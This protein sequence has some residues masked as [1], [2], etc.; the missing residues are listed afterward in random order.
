MKKQPYQPISCDFH[1]ELELLALRRIVCPIRYLGEQGSTI[2]IE[3]CISDLYTRNGEEF[4]LLPG[5]REIR[6]DRLISVNGILL[7]NY[8]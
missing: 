4:L 6:L 3:A 5:G 8:C 1:S 7:S 2:E